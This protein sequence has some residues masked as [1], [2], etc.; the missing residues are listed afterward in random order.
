MAAMVAA[1]AA[2]A[3]GGA[4]CGG[5]RPVSTVP[6]LEVTSSDSCSLLSLGKPLNMKVVPLK[7][8]LLRPRWVEERARQPLRNSAHIEV[9]QLRAVRVWSRE[10]VVH[11]LI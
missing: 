8:P 11:D 10:V 1:T 5:D 9:E 7:Q 6:P 4:S 2:S 3:S